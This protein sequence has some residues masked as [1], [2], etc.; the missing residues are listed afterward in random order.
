MR[1]Y[2]YIAE[3]GE[4][5]E[6]PTCGWPYDAGDYAWYGEGEYST[7]AGACSKAHAVKDLELL[8]RNHARFELTCPSWSTG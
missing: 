8:D 3:H 5:G 1:L 2:R 4:H 7:T 6:C